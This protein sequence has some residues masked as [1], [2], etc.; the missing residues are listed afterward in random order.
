MAYLVRRLLENS[1]N[2]GF[3]RKTFVADV[4]RETLLAAPEPWPGETE[5]LQRTDSG[6]FRNE[7]PL[8]FSLKANRAACRAAIDKVRSELGRTYPVVIGG[9]EYRTAD[10]IVSV[11][12]ANPGE[13]IGRV[14]G[15]DRD[16][17]DLAVTAAGKS[18]AGVG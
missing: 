18:A 17:I 12:P 13:V 4:G 10:A 15:I 8:D 7:P 16:L 9:K 6:P 5:P 14:C 1:S 3:L 11:N 2:E